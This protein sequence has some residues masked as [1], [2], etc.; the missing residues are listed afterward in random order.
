MAVLSDGIG[1]TFPS[2]LAF[3]LLFPVATV[4]YYIWSY[5]TSPLRKYPGPFFA[6][7]HRKYGP[8]VRLGP[9][10]L[11]LDYPTLISEIYGIKGDFRKTE[12]YHSSSAV[13][14]GQVIYNLF[15]EVDP[16]KHA[17]E[18]KPVAKY[19]STQGV[20]SLEP[21]V[22]STI[23]MLCEA[24][25]SRFMRGGSKGRACDL[26]EWIDYYA[27]DIV[28]K[29]T[30]SKPFGFLEK[31][32]DIDNTLKAANE[33]LDYFA[34]V[35]QIPI[36]DF[37]LAKNPVRP[38]GLSVYPIVSMSVQRLMERYNVA[39]AAWHNPEVPDF[40]DHFIEAKKLD[41]DHV[42][43]NQIIS[44]MMINSIAGAD[45][46]AIIV[47]DVLYYALKHPLV[48]E[49]LRREFEYRD[50]ASPVVEYREARDNAYLEAVVREASR[51]HPG[52]S[53]CLERYVPSRG[54][55]LPDGHGVVPAGVAVGINPFV[56]TRHSD[57]YG[58]NVDEFRPD[59][60]L[61]ALDESEDDFQKRL[62]AMKNA[63]LTFGAGSRVC[64]G[65][66]IALMEVYKVIAT[67]VVRYDIELAEPDAEWE[68]QNSFF[69]RQKGIY[70]HLSPRK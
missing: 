66:N 40:L 65:K 67:L 70:V 37:W 20:M 68:I 19:Y 9:N 63:D 60:W 30:F 54:L 18:K 27:W 15:S 59:R 55:I 10:L 28:G 31:G 44:W 5:T 41:P 16:V 57:I 39:D 13:R 43:D 7:L 47:K 23:V 4:L 50:V 42:D 3:A 36:L 21:H 17:K 32:D 29:T 45:T 11:D 33:S 46:T 6:D 35:G 38:I 58:K 2:P 25:E 1:N 22:D 8:V 48:W 14:S 56:M 62:R 64:I 12:F 26:G 53:M 24:L 69:V 49:R 34:R 52:I 51:M 61:Q